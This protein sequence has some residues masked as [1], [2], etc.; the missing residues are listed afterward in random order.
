LVLIDAPH[1]QGAPRALRKQPVGGVTDESKSFGKNTTPRVE[2]F[3]KTR[4]A[5]T[6]L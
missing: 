3:V 6:W 1:K 5:W 2:I 4:R